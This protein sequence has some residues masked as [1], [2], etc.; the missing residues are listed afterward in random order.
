MQLTLDR[1]ATQ[2]RRVDEVIVR[3]D[4]YPRLKSD[5]ALV[6]RYAAILDVLPPIEVNQHNILIDGYHRLTAHRKMEAETIQAVV[7]ETESDIDLL[8][9]AI[10]RNASHG[11]Q[12]SEDDKRKQ[13]I[14]LYAAGTG[15]SKEEIKRI[16]S[17]SLRSVQAYLENIDK[18]LEEER[19]QA[20][21][22]MWLTCETEDAIASAFGYKSRTT[23]EDT[24]S[25]F[26]ETMR[27]NAE[28]TFS[29]G[30]TPPIYN[31]WSFGK[32]TNEVSHFGNSEVRIVDNLLYL[33]T[34]PFDIVLDPFAGGGSTIGVCRKRF[35]RYW[36]SDRKPIVEREKEIR[37]LDIAQDLPPLNKRWSDVTLT[38]LDPP[39]WKQAEGQ[40]SDAAED[41]ANMPLD[42]FTDTLTGVVRRIAEKQ[43]RGAIALIIQPTQWKT[44]EAHDVTDHIRDLLCAT[45]K[46]KRL[47]LEYRVSCPYS[48]EQHTPQMV[49]W[50]KQNK[51]L[52][53]L[54][55]ELIVW[56][57]N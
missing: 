17:V 32:K 37:L 33:Y 3:E 27:K 12:L 47:T 39:Y 55:R 7:T 11:Y 14:R 20:I 56:R 26:C 10:E 4:L 42:E 46:S 57:V 52:L 30:F 28:V 23:V 1:P 13:A 5:P 9:L 16:L 15:K 43:S 53:V 22:D 48:T 8:A 21:I 6:Q 50:A 18:Q 34:E 41:L 2:T 36:V 19:K 24:L 40:Y 35:R 25:R 51:R 29:D 44:N 45:A 49:E 38:Y 31:I 54:T